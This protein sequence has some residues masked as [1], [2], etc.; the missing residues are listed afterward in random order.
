MAQQVSNINAE[1]DGNEVKITYDLLSNDP[2]G[3]FEIELYASHNNFI[4]PLEKVSGDVGKNIKPGDE[5]IIIWRPYEELTDF[6]GEIIFEVRATLIG[7]YYQVTHPA[8]SSK[9]KKKR[10]MPIEWKG[11]KSSEQVLIEIVK[12]GSPVLTIADRVTNS[13]SYKWT[14]PKDFTTGAGYQVKITNVNDPSLAGSSKVFKVAGGIP[15]W[16]LVGVPVVVG[17]AVAGVVMSGGEEP[18]N[19]PTNGETGTDLPLPPDGPGN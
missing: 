3:L 7:G 2:S 10:V 6:S 4:S 9:F 12:Y 1:M 16:L 19:G 18:I 17:G 8:S 14:V 15:T 5:K 13:G 11:G